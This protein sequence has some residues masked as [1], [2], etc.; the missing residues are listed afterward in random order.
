L[1]LE[2]RCEDYGQV[3]TYLGGIEDHPH[4]FELDDHHRFE[5]GRP[6]RVCGNTFDML[7]QSR[8]GRFFSLQGE[9]TTHFGLFDCA[10]A[11]AGVASAAP[12]GACC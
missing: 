3:A 6:L 1:A 9:K 2:D 10:P 4:A 7:A 12:A 8:Y 11:Q 5:T